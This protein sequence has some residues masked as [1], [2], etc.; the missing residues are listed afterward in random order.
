MNFLQKTFL[1]KVLKADKVLFG[2]FI[3]YIAGLL[4]FALKSREEFP[5]LLYGMYSLKEPA[6]PEYTTYEI[7]LA[8]QKVDY[9]RLWD[10]QR[11][12]ITANLS[13]YESLSTDKQQAFKEW[14][15]RY[16]ADMRTI[17]NNTLRVE[18]LHCAYTDGKPLVLKRE[19]LFDYAAP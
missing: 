13:A 4:F 3:F 19:T 7:F 15:F 8:G 5:F 6:K 2:F 14:L 10:S 18:K 11:E 9:S 12:L 16:V 17:D 1:Y